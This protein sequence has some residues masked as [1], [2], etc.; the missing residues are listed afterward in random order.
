MRSIAVIYYSETGNTETVAHWIAQGAETVPDTAARLFNIR[1]DEAPDKEYIE[2]CDAVVFGTPTYVA[3][4]CWQMKKWFDTRL[5]YRLA[6]KIGSAF[7][8]ENSPNGGGG[9]LAIMTIVG[10][11]LVKGMLV[12]SSG[13]GCGR[14]FIH[15]GPAVVKSQLAEREE[16]C[17]LFGKRIAD[18]AHRLFDR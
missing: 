8:T 1:E 6:G 3:N 12:Y 17:N 2:G 4:M 9:E 7:S 14:P 11:M 15:I 13:S 5:D 18:Q 16:I 10:H